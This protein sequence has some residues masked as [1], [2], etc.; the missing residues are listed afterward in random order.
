MAVSAGSGGHLCALGCASGCWGPEAAPQPHRFCNR[1]RF[2]AVEFVL[3]PA[4]KLYHGSVEPGPS[5]SSA[6]ARIIRSHPVPMATPA[7]PGQDASLLAMQ[8]LT[9]APAP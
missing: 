1:L 5:G 7:F 2:P 9:T 4:R 6:V 3:N 8:N